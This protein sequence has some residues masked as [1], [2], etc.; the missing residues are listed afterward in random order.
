MS[1]FGFSF[2]ELYPYF[3]KK[4][5]ENYPND[6]DQN[7]YNGKLKLDVSYSMMISS[8]LKIHYINAN[9]MC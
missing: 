3:N 4:E 8:V 1:G 7:G 6:L 2:A 9:E 5:N